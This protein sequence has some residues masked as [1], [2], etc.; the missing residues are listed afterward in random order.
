MSKYLIL[1]PNRNSKNLWWEKRVARTSEGRFDRRYALRAEADAAGA[2]DEWFATT[3]KS[4]C[5]SKLRRG[6]V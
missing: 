5:G 3:P 2:R 6:H 1:L 4:L